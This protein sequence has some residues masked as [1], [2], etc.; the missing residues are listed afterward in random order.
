[1]IQP[2]VKVWLEA[3]EDSRP[4]YAF[5]FGISEI[6]KA[7][8]RSGSIKGAA[9]VVGKSYRHVWDRIKSAEAAIGR[10]LVDSRVG[11]EGERRSQ[12]TES[13]RKLI[14]EFDALREQVVHI[15]QDVFAER[16]QNV[17]E[18]LNGS[19]ADARGKY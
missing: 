8:D 9:V 11:G 1:M 2:R 16:I 12:L 15:V 7:V 6:L 17:L 10:S 14:A 19:D 5:G 3:V 13:A 4:K 18:D